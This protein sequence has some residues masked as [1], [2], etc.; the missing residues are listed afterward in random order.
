NYRIIHDAAYYEENNQKDEYLASDSSVIRQN[1]TIEGVKEISDAIV[2]TLIKE[3]LIK[4]DLQER[5]LSLFDWSRLNATGMWT[6]A[7]YDSAEKNIVFMDI[8]PDGH[9]EFRKVDP[10][11]LDWYAKYQEYVEILKGAKDSKW[12]THLSPEGLVVSEAGDKNLIYRTEETTIPNLKEIR[13]I[14][15]EVDDELPEG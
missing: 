8:F 2:K 15:K 14:I 7:A 5:N 6:F 9:F 10:T 12:Q 3:Q 1:I 11:S 13:N 4:R